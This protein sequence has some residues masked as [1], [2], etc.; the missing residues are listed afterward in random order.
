MIIKDK[1][2]SSSLIS[3]SIG[4]FLQ[5]VLVVYVAKELTNT[6]S[7]VYFTIGILSQLTMALIYGFNST[8]LRLVNYSST[9]IPIKEFKNI[10]H[11]THQIKSQEST[12]NELLLIRRTIRKILIKAS[13]LYLAV[14]LF[15]GFFFLKN[16]ISEVG[17]NFFWVYFIFYLLINSLGITFSSEQIY[18]RGL[19]LIPNVEKQYFISNF[20][21]IIITFLIIVFLREDIN[22]GHLLCLNAATLL[23]PNLLIYLSSTP[24]QITPT[25]YKKSETVKILNKE[26]FSS[27]LK[28]GFTSSLG[29]I[30]KNI[31]SLFVV[32]YFS[33]YDS[34]S[35]LFTKKLIDIVE[36]ITMTIYNSKIP[37]L[38]NL[39]VTDIKKFKLLLTSISRFTQNIFIIFSIGI[40]FLGDYF[41]TLINFNSTLVV[42]PVLILM[43]ISSM[44]QR[45]AGI[46]LAS[47]NQSNKIIEHIYAIASIAMLII[48][49]GTLYL[50]ELI[51]LKTM[52]AVE[53]LTLFLC[54]I[55]FFKEHYSSLNTT[56]IKFEKN[57]ILTRIL[58]LVILFL[59][60][61]I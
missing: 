32:S 37:T 41:I 5:L 35:F 46:I 58:F 25:Y 17:L 3:K 9:G 24:N 30:S 45:W 38:N 2:I 31:S 28:T 26:I 29:S 10:K 57:L 36:N 48:F 43:L 42:A 60:Y 6:E 27:T 13:T 61:I 56:F 47:F 8:L 22:V 34:S 4:L 44:V 33:V 53:I 7:T 16:I 18:L 12:K 23:F 1:D 40:V 50:F 59:I 14:F 54:S 55:I 15:L 49:L 52:V 39:R 11:K 21:L 19:G 20:V 51:N